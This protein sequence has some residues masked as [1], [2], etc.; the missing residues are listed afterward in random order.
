MAEDSELDEEELLELF[1]RFDQTGDGEVD[2]EEFRTILASLGETP[3]DEVLSLDFAVIDKD[4][5]GK[6]GFE[7]F[8][9]WWL[10]K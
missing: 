10:D 9:A 3:T 6:V 5:D 1:S 8:K 7:E 2:I 4:E